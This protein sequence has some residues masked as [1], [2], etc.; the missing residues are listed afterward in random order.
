MSTDTHD[1]PK[2]VAL[3]KKLFTILGV[4]TALG[5]GMAFLH[6]PVWLAVVAAVAIII[7][8]GGVVVDVFKPLLATRPILV[9]VFGLTVFFVIGL[10]MLPVINKGTIVGT[11]DL[12][13]EIQMQQQPVEV[14]H[15]N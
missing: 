8:K 1:V 4:I 6:M 15:G 11:H 3:Y 7:V 13:K 9:I 10:I 12:S 14:H 2:M 5:I